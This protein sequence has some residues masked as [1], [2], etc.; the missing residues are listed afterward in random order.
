MGRIGADRQHH[1]QYQQRHHEGDDGEVGIRIAHHGG[2][3]GDA[4]GDIACRVDLDESGGLIALQAECFAQAGGVQGFTRDEEAS[5]DRGGHHR[6]Q[7]A[8]RV[9]HRGGERPFQRAERPGGIHQQRYHHHRLAQGVEHLDEI[10]VVAIPVAGELR[11][12]Q[13]ADQDQHQARGHHVAAVDALAIDQCRHQRCQ[14]Q[15]RQRHGQHDREQLHGAIALHF[16]QEGGGNGAGGQGQ[17]H[18]GTQGDEAEG[19]VAAC[20][21]LQLVERHRVEPLMDQEGHEDQPAR[22]Q[23]GD[24]QR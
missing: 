11:A 4:R 14:Q 19:K 16:P 10:E 9:D 8:Q 18:E 21:Q 20:Q 1:D 2:L 23:Q 24:D 7:G 5:V 22:G 12:Q 15:L 6:E 13:A 17:E 3:L